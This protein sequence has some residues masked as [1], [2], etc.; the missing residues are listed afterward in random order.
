[1]KWLPAFVV[2]ATIANIGCNYCGPEQH[3]ITTSANTLTLGGDFGTRQIQFVT[4]RLTEPPASHDAFQFVFNTLEGSANGEGVALTLSGTDAI[5]QEIVTIVLALPVSL[6]EDDEYS[7]GGTFSVEVGSP[8]ET[9]LWGAHDLLESNKA[10]VAFVVATY[11]FPPPVYTSN[12]RAVASTGAIR[13]VNRTR[14]H[15]QLDLNL[16]FTDATS[17]LRTVTGDAE[18]NTEKSAALCN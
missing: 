9:R 10:D 14:G 4:Y 6:R 1:M 12:F 16:T 15:V 18:A 7:V 17:N 11:S 2:A 8:A 13:V 5:T 3:A